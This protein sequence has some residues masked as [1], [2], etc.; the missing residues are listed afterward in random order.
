MT[1]RQ[2]AA[3][4]ARVLR[5]LRTLP[6]A[7]A[8]EHGA[9]LSLEVRGKRFGWY[10]DDHHGDGRLAAH[11]RAPPGADRMLAAAAPAMFHVPAHVGHRGWVGLWLDVPKPDWAEVKAALGDAYRMTAPKTL[12]GRP[13]GAGHS[14]G[15]TRR[16]RARRSPASGP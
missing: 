7:T 4:R 1:P 8:A 15:P 3:R 11:L 10:L 6:D 2:R 5:L 12:A 16:R 14:K 13:R 9:H